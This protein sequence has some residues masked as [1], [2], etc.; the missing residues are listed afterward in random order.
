M[1]E[2]IHAVTFTSLSNVSLFG[3]EIRDASKRLAFFRRCCNWRNPLEINL[4]IAKK[5][6]YGILFLFHRYDLCA[7]TILQMSNLPR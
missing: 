7:W 1:I 6:N 4:A 3:I 5:G 2:C